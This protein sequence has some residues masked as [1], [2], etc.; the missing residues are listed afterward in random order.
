VLDAGHDCGTALASLGDLDGD[1]GAEVAI[2]C[3]AAAGSLGGVYTLSLPPVT[4]LGDMPPAFALSMK[5]L[6]RSQGY[7][8]PGKGSIAQPSLGSSLSATSHSRDGSTVLA[9]VSSATEAGSPCPLGAPPFGSISLVKLTWE[10][11]IAAATLTWG[12]SYVPGGRVLRCTHADAAAVERATFIG[13]IDGNGFSDLAGTDAQQE[14][15]LLFLNSALHIDSQVQLQVAPGLHAPSGSW[16]SIVSVGVSAADGTALIAAGT[17]A[18]DIGTVWLLA[19][20]TDG[21]LGA[22]TH[23]RQLGGSTGVSTLDTILH[24]NTAAFG[25]SVAAASDSSGALQLVVGAPGSIVGGVRLGAV[26]SIATHAHPAA[27]DACAGTTSLGVLCTLPR[28]GAAAAVRSA[29][30]LNATTPLPELNNGYSST[31]PPSTAE[32]LGHALALV[33]DVNGDGWADWVA[34]MPTVDDAGQ[35]RL[36]AGSSAGP[37]PVSQLTFWPHP[38]LNTAGLGE[39]GHS[40]AALGDVDG[41]GIPDLAMG[42]PRTTNPTL[43]GVFILFLAHGGLLHHYA[44]VQHQANQPASHNL[45]NTSPGTALSA[46][47][48]PSGSRGGVTLL[49]GDED[50]NA[51]KGAVSVAQLDAVGRVIVSAAHMDGSAA[52]P[53]GAFAGTDQ[54]G[55]G[56]LAALGDIGDHTGH[57]DGHAD[58]VVSDKT[59]DAA[60]PS[61]LHLVLMSGDGFALAAVEVLPLKL[62]AGPGGGD[63]NAGSSNA[64][65]IWAASPLVRFTNTGDQRGD[66]TPELLVVTNGAQPLLLMASI[67]RLRSEITLTPVAAH[68]PSSTDVNVVGG[69]VLVPRTGDAMVAD[70]LVGLPA[71]V[72]SPGGQV[73]HVQLGLSL[74]SSVPGGCTPALQLL[75][76]CR[77]AAGTMLR[78]IQPTAVMQ[79]GAFQDLGTAATV[80]GYAPSGDILVAVGAPGPGANSGDPHHG[81]VELLAI[82]FNGCLLQS[83]STT[84]VGSIPAPQLASVQDSGQGARFGAAVAALGDDNG[85]GWPDLL[86]GAPAAERGFGLAFVVHLQ[87]GEDAPNVLDFE[88]VSGGVSQS[89]GELGHSVCA[90][91]SFVG[92]GRPVMFL[93]A[94]GYNTDVGNVVMV[95]FAAGVERGTAITPPPSGAHRVGLSCA[96]LQSSVGDGMAL[97]AVGR[98]GSSPDGGI[99][100]LMAQ[101]GLGSGFPP[102]LSIVGAYDG[103]GSPRHPQ[104]G[105]AM[106]LLRTSP[107]PDASSTL[108]VRSQDEDSHPVVEVLDLSLRGGGLLR[109]DLVGR[110]SARDVASSS[111]CNGSTIP[112]CS[113]GWKV[114][115]ALPLLS[116]GRR[117][118]SMPL[119]VGVET[120]PGEHELWLGATADF[121]SPDNE[122]TS[123]T[124]QANTVDAL[125]AASLGLVSARSYAQGSIVQLQSVSTQ[126]STPMFVAASQR[127]APRRPAGVGWTS[128]LPLG[129]WDGNGVGDVVTSTALAAGT[130]PSQPLGSVAILL[131]NAN[132]AAEQALY[133]HGEDLEEVFHLGLNNRSRFAFRVAVAGDWDGDGRS[134]L[135]ASERPE[136]FEQPEKYLHVFVLH[137]SGVDG[138]PR[139]V[140]SLTDPARGFTAPRQPSFDTQQDPFGFAL[141]AAAL[142]APS[143][144]P[145]PPGA[146]ADPPGAVCSCVLIKDGEGV[147]LLQA[148]APAAP[149]DATQ[150][151]HITAWTWLSFQHAVFIGLPVPSAPTL[152]H[153]AFV[154]SVTAGAQ[155]TNISD[156]ALLLFPGAGS[157]HRPHTLVLVSLL[158][159][160]SPGSAVFVGSTADVFSVLPSMYTQRLTATVSSLGDI[161]GNGVDDLALSYRHRDLEPVSRTITPLLMQRGGDK[162]LLRHQPPARRGGVACRVCHRAI[163]R[164]DNC[165]FW[166]P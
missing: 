45:T 133:I 56:G 57:P 18:A 20:S 123:T 104:F 145:L 85:D 146:I 42:V 12:A 72:D 103:V 13:D 126:D 134:E 53:P 63:P 3:P 17:Q 163:H 74:P 43:K 48:G 120:S 78:P 142:H 125:R 82:R 93:G 67:D 150:A 2:S 55:G 32:L 44:L 131:L 10:G 121:S 39:F 36:F 98:S 34:G 6:M 5:Q 87:W 151:S 162:D 100:L 35:A 41:N 75:G 115:L 166:L 139:L 105:S 64:A 119:L 37:I 156:V 165:Q 160:G 33:G 157:G 112:F 153:A 47:Q 19:L 122:G 1:G 109:A 25:A 31:H 113:P 155:A 111:A 21:T 159:D 148:V 108:L 116:T 60:A 94:P 147:W 154:G 79:G 15:F 76:L 144:S 90:V 80:L 4:S 140:Y 28:V 81:Q 124:M 84:V 117:C 38:G 8:F 29:S 95:D 83:A 136:L 92:H 52:M 118:A 149:V 49:M 97:L 66:A 161:D 152:Q 69:I 143:C 65:A 23:S 96:V 7:T 127:Q 51:L 86:V 70:A 68:L 9:A 129:D 22:I 91:Q 59:S 135:L 138:T 40:M 46:L 130:A 101:I 50:A 99:M 62:A 89:N 58:Y 114:T 24:G 102:A 61:R 128:L 54:L 88:A 26:W 141:D 16:A 107:A 11:S 106:H 73:Q 132:G 158:R 137:L 14:P 164:R 30:L 27:V 71:S 110:L 77:A